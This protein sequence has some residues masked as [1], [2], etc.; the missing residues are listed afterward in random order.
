MILTNIVF[1]EIGE[2]LT[3]LTE[4]AKD[5]ILYKK[6]KSVGTTRVTHVIRSSPQHDMVS[7]ACGTEDIT[8]NEFVFTPPGLFKKGSVAEIIVK[9]KRRPNVNWHL[10]PP[11]RVALRPFDRTVLDTITPEDE[12]NLA[13]MFKHPSNEKEPFYSRAFYRKFF[14]GAKKTLTS[15]P[16]VNHSTKS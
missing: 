7:I 9:V 2:H 12:T 15:F 11:C 5:A 13:P 4:S 3:Q 16:D 1:M 8:G 14:K 6:P 10:Y